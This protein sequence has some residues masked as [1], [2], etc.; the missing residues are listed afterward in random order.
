MGVKGSLERF[1][2]YYSVLQAVHHTS[3]CIMR[4]HVGSSGIFLFPL[5]MNARDLWCELKEN[6]RA[7]EQDRI[8]MEL[9]K[10]LLYA[11]VPTP[12]AERLEDGEVCTCL[13]FVA[14]YSVLVMACACLLAC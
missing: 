6:D 1:R 2:A 3:N 13:C 8:E 14:G 12:I 10:N 9:L 7:L 5:W 4:S 11:L